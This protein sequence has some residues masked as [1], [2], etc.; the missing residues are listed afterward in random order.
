MAPGRNHYYCLP[1]VNLKWDGAV[2]LDDTLID[3]TLNTEKK[4][5]HFADN[6]QFESTPVKKAKAH[7]ILGESHINVHGIPDLTSKLQDKKATKSK[8]PCRCLHLSLRHSR[9]PYIQ[10]FCGSTLSGT[11]LSFQLWIQNIEST[12]SDRNL[13]KGETFCLIKDF[14]KG[15]AKDNINFY[16]ETTDN[17]TVEGLFDNLRQVLSLG[18]DSQQMLTEFYSWSQG[19]KESAKEFGESAPNSS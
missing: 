5:I 9:E 17:S 19:A 18:E 6:H 3:W 11:L 1:T 10:C 13:S 8:T 15:S 4:H 14:S 12:I 7:D 2:P 16:L